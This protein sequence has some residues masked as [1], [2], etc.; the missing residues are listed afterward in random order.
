MPTEFE[1]AI[2]QF[3]SSSL[4]GYEPTTPNRRKAIHDALWGTITLSPAEIALLD[5]PL[6]QRLRSIHQTGFAFYVYPSANHSRLEHS[7]G[8]LAI[9]TRL[10]ESLNSKVSKELRIT[11]SERQQL[12]LAALLHDC[13]HGIL[14]HISEYFYEQHHWITDLKKDPIYEQAKA[15]E[16]MSYMIVKSGAFDKF[17]TKIRKK[18]GKKDRPIGSIDAVKLKEIANLIIGRPPS[19]EKAYLAGIINGPFDADKLDYI[20]RDSYFTGLRLAVDIERLLYALDVAPV[21]TETGKENRLVAL[22]SASSVLEQ[23]LFSKIQL[24]PALYQHAKVKAT[25]SMLIAFLEYMRD[26]PGPLKYKGQSQILLSTPI[27]FLRFTDYDLLNIRLRGDRTLQNTIRCLR[28][29]KLWLKALVISSNTVDENMDEITR[30]IENENRQDI[31]DGLKK[32]IYSRI[33]NSLKGTVYD[34]VVDFPKLAPIREAALQVVLQ[35][36]GEVVTLNSLFPAHDWLQSYVEKKWKGHV[37]CP[38]PIQHA[39]NNAAIEVLESK[40]HVKF[41]HLATDLANLR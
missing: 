8:V 36:D 35:P 5:C 19:P 13:G 11:Q 32:E 23:I 1:A 41:N 20:P 29:R 34:I 2:E 25:D 40:L 21:E 4:S 38:E 18:Y 9:T 14:S 37:F 24:Y 3:V 28:E 30:L 33:P 6:L 16:L 7:I 27:D 12:R 17:F 10:I 22:A 26:L 15:H 39:V 31:L